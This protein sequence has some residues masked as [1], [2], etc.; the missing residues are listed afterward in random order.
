MQP[1][2][3]RLNNPG[4]IRKG[5]NWQGLAPVQNDANFCTFIDAEHGIR[6][7][8]KILGT[9]KTKYKVTRLQDVIP[10]YAPPSENKTPEYLNNVS[11]WSGIEADASIDLQDASTLER[12]VPA[13]IRQE[14][15]YQPYDTATLNR[16][17][18]LGIGTA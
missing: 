14:Q 12:I 2:G 10:R 6:A 4:N 3:I 1:L 7:I 5:E 17:I 11:K 13:I 15:G 9:Y 18:A 8:V 16:G